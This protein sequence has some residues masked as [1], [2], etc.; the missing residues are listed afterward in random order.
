MSASRRFH[1]ERSSW[2]AVTRPLKRAGGRHA[3]VIFL[4]LV[5]GAL[6]VG[7]GGGA[8]A[9]LYGSPNEMK[10]G[11]LLAS[12]LESHEHSG[13]ESV[14]C[15]RLSL[16]RTGPYGYG[17]RCRVTTSSSALIC[18]AMGT[19]NWSWGANRLVG[20]SCDS[21][22]H[23]H[24]V[25]AQTGQLVR[26]ALSVLNQD[27]QLIDVMSA[28]QAE[29]A[30]IACSVHREYAGKQ[31]T[32]NIG[33]NLIVATTSPPMPPVADVVVTPQGL[34]TIE[35]V[36]RA[37]APGLA[38]YASCAFDGTSFAISPTP[39][40]V[41]QAADTSHAKVISASEIGTASTPPTTSGSTRSS[42][43]SGSALPK[44]ID[45]GKT[46]I[47]PANFQYVGD[48]SE[49]LGGFDGNGTTHYGH[50]RWSKWTTSEADA[51]GADWI[52]PCNP[53]CAG[54]KFSPSTA[55]V[56]LFDPTNG[57][58]TRLTVRE[59]HDGKPETLQFYA[60]VPSTGALPSYIPWTACGTAYS[61]ACP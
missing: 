2:T 9:K 3:A 57:Y 44:L 7:C 15:Q 11:G 25:V 19:G 56:R 27:T 52:D 39:H 17:Y 49:M 55:T 4:T 61:K 48:A 45:G 20:S 36:K 29:G 24:R 59:I 51:S 33:F 60:S 40:V 14:R 35:H 54:G 8:S 34:L 53:D 26:Q 22:S 58:F 41:M 10:I 42:T 30:T 50:L 1:G 46:P 6:L 47:R 38:V 13:I 18:D 28:Y 12:Y 23:Y 31:L 37:S 21:A 16:N 32:A 43:P 5:L